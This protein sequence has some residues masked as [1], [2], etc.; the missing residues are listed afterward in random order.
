MFICN[1]SLISYF[2]S[3]FPSHVRVKAIDISSPDFKTFYS[4]ISG[5]IVDI[6]KFEIGRPNK[7]SK[8]N[9]DYLTLIHDD[10]GTKIKILHVLPYFQKGDY[11]KE[12][13]KFGEFLETPY[14]GG[15]FPHAHVEGL[16][17]RFPKIKRYRESKVGIVKYKTKDFF[18]IIIKDFSE[19]GNLRGL[20]C[21]NGL[22][23]A[24]IPYACYG[25]II[26][27][28]KEPVNLYGISLGRIVM[29][30]KTYALFEGRNGILRNWEKEAS[31]KVLAN[32]PICGFAFMEIVLSYGGCPMI[33]FFFNNN[34]IKEGEEIELST[35]I[36][37]HLGSKIY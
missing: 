15:D 30:R 27:G 9:Y 2:T 32:K 34:E 21:C 36:R 6:I 17:I 25:G 23:N 8:I 29:K 19:A 3:G 31:F 16:T 13:D 1:K 24:S 35:L 22:L 33:R 28:Y 37:N 11:V 26:G 20:G 14:T 5:E 4:P 7:F 12:G 10:K 18:D